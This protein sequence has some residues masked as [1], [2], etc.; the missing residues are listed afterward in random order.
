MQI[1]FMKLG[2]NSRFHEQLGKSGIGGDI[3]IAALYLSVEAESYRSRL[4]NAVA[5]STIEIIEDLLGG[6]SLSPYR[7][8]SKHYGT[9]L[10]V[11][12][13]EGPMGMS[14]S[15]DHNGRACVSRLV[16]NGGAE[17]KGVR[18]GDVVEM[19]GGKRMGG[20]DQIMRMIPMLPRPLSIV[21][22]RGT[23]ISE[24][25]LTKEER[26]QVADDCGQE[27]SGVSEQFPV[28]PGN[29]HCSDGVLLAGTAA[30]EIS[31]PV[32]LSTL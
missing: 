6:T 2:G 12:F 17:T 23:D 1:L 18:V 9:H 22:F 26:D 20:Y 15:K 10:D 25:D 32:I 29:R 4:K 5:N 19:V 8:N 11:T 24:Q 28:P 13:M 30:E 27:G 16:S 31:P 3:S 14:I 7:Y 21:F